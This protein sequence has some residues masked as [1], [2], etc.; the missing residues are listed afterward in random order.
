M[1]PDSYMVS[2][3]DL[4]D[5]RACLDK[6]LTVAED[7]REAAQNRQETL[8]AA[9]NLV[10]EET[11][12]V[13]AH[14]HARSRP[15]VDGDQDGSFLDAESTNPHP[16]SEMRINLG[17]A[18]LRAA[19]L[20]LALCSAVTDGDR[21]WVRDRAAV[22]LGSNDEHLINE[23]AVTLSKLGAD[24]MGELDGI[25]LAGHPLPVVRQLATVVAAARPVGTPRL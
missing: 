16:L 21:M 4:A 20:R 19:G 3:L 6:M 14:V 18:S 10:L 24:V 1:V 23:G 8:T 25:L 13:K 15:F 9:S 5:G 22:M 7:R 12:D 11:E 17:S 2:F